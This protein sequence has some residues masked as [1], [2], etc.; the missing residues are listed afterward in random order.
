MISKS[1][2]QSTNECRMISL[3]KWEIAIFLNLQRTIH[4]TDH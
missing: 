1:R 2:T 3:Q 4:R